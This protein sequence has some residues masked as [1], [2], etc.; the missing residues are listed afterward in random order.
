MGT[1]RDC[2]GMAFPYSLL[3]TSKFRDLNVQG[4]GHAFGSRA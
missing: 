2:M 4:V 1:C 3:S